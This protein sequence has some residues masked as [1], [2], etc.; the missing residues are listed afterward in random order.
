MTTSH[1]NT[2]RILKEIDAA[3]A[4]EKSK[5]TGEKY[6]R[7]RTLGDVFLRSIIGFRVSGLLIARDIVSGS[8]GE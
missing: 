1:R 2:D 3:I 5:L 8:V 4:Y 6:E 7:L